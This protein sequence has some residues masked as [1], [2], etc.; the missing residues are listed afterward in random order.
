[1]VIDIFSYNGEADILEIRLNILDSVVDQ[2][3]ICEGDETTAGVPK[4]RYFEENKER[5]AK[6]LP[7]I[8]HHVFSPYTDPALSFL[9]D[10]SP[11]VPKD[12]HWWRREFIQK[13]SMRYALTHLHDEDMVMI[14]DVDEIPRPDVVQYLKTLYEKKTI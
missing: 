6:W 1:M 3:I 11:G 14:G 8:K 4:P 12:M 13:E 9:V 2:F 10:Q 5:Y 7:K